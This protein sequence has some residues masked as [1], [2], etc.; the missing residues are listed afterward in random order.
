[1]M[2]ST[3]AGHQAVS[4]EKRDG[5][6]I[7]RCDICGLRGNSRTGHA[8][9]LGRVECPGVATVWPPLEG[10]DPAETGERFGA[11]LAPTEAPVDGAVLDAP[12]SHLHP[13]ARNPRGAVDASSPGIRDFARSISGPTGLLQPI[14]VRPRSTPH[15]G[16][17]EVIA[18]HRRLAAA[19]VAG[20]SQVRVIVRLLD[21]A[22]ALEAALTENADS[23]RMPI[24]VSAEVR[25]VQA[26]VSMGVDIAALKE[27]LGRDAEWVRDRLAL[28]ALQSGAAFDALDR[29][30]LQVRPAVALA[31]LPS[32][33]QVRAVAVLTPAWA[34]G[35]ATSPVDVSRAIH[36]SKLRLATAPWGLDDETIGTRGSCDRCPVRSD[37]QGDLWRL[38][39]EVSCLDEGCWQTKAQEH[40]RRVRTVEARA[41]FER[42]EAG[43]G[44]EAGESALDYAS[45][46]RAAGLG[47]AADRKARKERPA[48]VEEPRRPQRLRPTVAQVNEVLERLVATVEADLGDTTIPLPVASH[49]L[50]CLPW[51]LDMVLRRRGLVTGACLADRVYPG[52]GGRGV[53]TASQIIDRWA[54]TATP[55][56]VLGFLVEVS[57]AD[58]ARNAISHSP[59]PATGP[60]ARLVRWAQLDLP[61]GLIAGSEA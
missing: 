10:D 21:D 29:G 22:A 56:Q 59:R 32:T 57:V 36:R 48:E 31:T 3:V 44:D 47:P 49:A 45:N 35:R 5:V 61:E 25:A 6:W 51:S 43:Q 23:S 52:P 34:D 41:E 12:V 1:M 55:A 37:S 40:A 8:E 13:W 20:L 9:F 24:P 26:L 16:H 17:W 19:Q 39:D 30:L 54:A 38:D 2:R 15:D 42:T 18:G 11:A 7:F 50:P 28:V 53:E 58:E 4:T 60:L 46:A 33:L 14:V 27:R